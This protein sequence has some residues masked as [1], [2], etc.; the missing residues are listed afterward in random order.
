MDIRNK[1][2]LRVKTL[3]VTFKQAYTTH[4]RSHDIT[5]QNIDILLLEILRFF[6]A[7]TFDPKV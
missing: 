4:I 2:L 1:E 5:L 6:N 7:I 3:N